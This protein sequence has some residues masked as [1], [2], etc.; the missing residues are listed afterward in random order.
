M[1]KWGWLAFGVLVWF[2][3]FT[4]ALA[5]CSRSPYAERRYHAPPSRVRRVAP[6]HD[7]KRDEEECA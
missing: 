3:L 4:L 6:P 1:T 2:A 7:W 5:L